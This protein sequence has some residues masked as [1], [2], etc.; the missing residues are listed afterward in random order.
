MICALVLWPAAECSEAIAKRPLAD[1]FTTD[2]LP[3]EAAQCS[4]VDAFSSRALG[5]AP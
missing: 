3:Q 4:G 2:L 5:S 1:V